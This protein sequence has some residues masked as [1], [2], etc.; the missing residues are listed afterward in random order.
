M[1]RT[2]YYKAYREMHK[3]AISKDKKLYYKKHADKLKSDRKIY[4]KTHSEKVNALASKRYSNEKNQLH[5]ERNDKLIQ[6]IFGISTRISKCLQFDY[7][8]DHIIPLS[9]GGWHHE[10]NLQ[11]ISMR[12][13]VR[14][15]NKLDFQHPFLK[16]SEDVPVFLKTHLVVSDDKYQKC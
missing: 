6:C 4:R 10:E 5:P 12:L 1:D 16:T 9:K 11:V 14:K 3:A 2:E 15:N 7:E 13:N 8:V